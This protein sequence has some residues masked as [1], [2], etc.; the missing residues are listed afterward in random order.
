[1][2]QRRT[3]RIIQQSRN[4]PTAYDGVEHRTG[5]GK[6]RAVAAH[7]Q[8]PG[9]DRFDYVSAVL[10]GNRLSGAAVVGVL[11][12]AASAAVGD[13][14]YIGDVFGEGIC[15]VE[16]ITLG[17]TLGDDQVQRMVGAVAD[18]IAEN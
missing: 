18:R 12:A 11:D 3:A 1:M 17:Y 14:G 4:A 5:S 15:A 10:S 13:I 7:R 8:V 9:H 16:V 6:Q 2:A